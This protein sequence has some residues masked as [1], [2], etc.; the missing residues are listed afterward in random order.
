MKTRKRRPLPAALCALIMLV[1]SIVLGYAAYYG[2]GNFKDVFV[3]R[4]NS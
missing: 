3:N 4:R 2:K 1:L